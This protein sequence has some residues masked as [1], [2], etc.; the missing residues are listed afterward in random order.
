[1][2]PVEDHHLRSEAGT[3]LLQK[4][5]ISLRALGDHL[6]LSSST[7]SIVLNDAPGA[8]RIPAHTRERIK[9]AARQLGYSP[10][11]RAQSMRK[12]KSR[13][14][15][16][17][18][19]DLVDSHSSQIL[20]GVE[21]HLVERGYLYLTASHHRDAALMEKYPRLLSD[22]S[23][24]GLLLIHTVVDQHGKMPTVAIACPGDST[25]AP[26]VVFDHLRSAE[27]VLSH[28]SSL[29]HRKIAV[30]IGTADKPVVEPRLEALMAAA[31]SMKLELLHEL[32]SPTRSLLSAQQRGYMPVREL[33]LAGAEFTAVICLDDIAAVGAMRAIADQ[34]L[35][36]PADLS[37]VGYDE[38]QNAH[39]YRPSLTTVRQPL[40]QMGYLAA[41]VL[42]QRIAGEDSSPDTLS[43]EPELQVRKSTGPAKRSHAF[44][45]NRCCSDGCVDQLCNTNVA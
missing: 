26:H 21:E 9:S 15:G 22:R 31:E 37:V 36:V 41:S 25:T 4:R 19:P 11:A 17:L 32:P 14:I 29:G 27:L 39:F 13:T 38:V 3:D 20:I 28:L 24:E 18:M 30:M 8:G 42:L 45:C 40:R 12:V 16:V 1:L 33:L 43:I 44:A 7:I 6:A 2:S 5:K 23:I 10:D 35:Q 34:G